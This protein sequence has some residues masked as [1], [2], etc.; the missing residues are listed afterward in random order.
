VNTHLTHSLIY[1]ARRPLS[2]AIDPSPNWAQLFSDDELENA[3]VGIQGVFGSVRYV[4]PDAKELVGLVDR[5]KASLPPICDGLQAD[6]TVEL[7]ETD[8]RKILH[9][10]WVFWAGRERLLPPSTL[11]FLKTNRLCNQALLQ[12]RA[13][14]EYKGS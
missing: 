8:F 13:I 1:P 11:S 6:G 10:G 3:V 14:N 2:D 12:Q 5:L 7:V 9:A 4:P